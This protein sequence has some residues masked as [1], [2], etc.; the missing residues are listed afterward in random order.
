MHATAVPDHVRCGYLIISISWPRLLVGLFVSIFVA[1]ILAAVPDSIAEV[2]ALADQPQPANTVS[3][4]L[5][6]RLVTKRAAKPLRSKPKPGSIMPRFCVAR[7]GVMSGDK[8]HPAHLDTPG[9][10]ALSSGDSTYCDWKDK[11]E[12]E[13]PFRLC[14]FDRKEDT[15]VS[16]YIHKE[17]VWAPYKRE[18]MERALPVVHPDMPMPG[19][20][21][22]IDIGANIGFFTLIAATRGYDTLA[23]EPSHE[24]VTR[25]LFSYQGNKIDVIQPDEDGAP[26]LGTTLRAGPDGIPATVPRPPVAVVFENAASDSYASMHLHVYA[27]NPGASFVSKDAAEGIPT[28][29]VFL[30]DL[31]DSDSREPG[32]THPGLRFGPVLTPSNVRLIKISAEGFDSRSIHGMR[33]LL[34]LGRVPFLFFVYNQ[35]HIR[36]HDCDP[37]DLLMSLFSMGYRLY[38]MGTYIYRE[39]E[40]ARFLKGMT[41]RSTELQL[42]AEGV[43]FF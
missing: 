11:T 5:S 23:I 1:L 8:W 34:S 17:G 28:T 30:D 15:Q 42:V 16:A 40:L 18:L 14:T 13:V 6:S 36:E 3:T 9:Y 41:A 38:F 29:T 27:D 43:D 22:V 25:L 35:D 33:R 20:T 24:A 2:A 7:S 31:L 26:A 21:L 19:R 32:T 4:S 37:K 12:T 10:P 39:L